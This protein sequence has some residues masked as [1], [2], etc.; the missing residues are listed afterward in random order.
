MNLPDEEKPP[1]PEPEPHPEPSPK[2]ATRKL[3]HQL[4]TAQRPDEGQGQP[5]S[6]LG[7][8]EVKQKTAETRSASVHSRRQVPEQTPAGPDPVSQPG[9]KVRN[10]A[11]GSAPPREQSDP[12]SKLRRIEDAGRQAPPAKLPWTY[13]LL[14]NKERTR[15]A[16][17]D[18]GSLLSVVGNAVL[19][20]LVMAFQ[21]RHL[22]TT[23]NGL[24]GGLYGNFGALGDATIST[25]ITLEAQVP[26]S[27]ML[28][29]QQLT[30]VTLTEAVVIPNTNLVMNSDSFAING[31]ARITLPRGTNLPIALTMD[32]PVQTT[33]P[34]SLLVPVTIPLSQTQLSSSFRNLQKVIQP[35][36]CTLNVD[37]Q[38]PE[39]I[40]LCAEHVTPTPLP[41]TP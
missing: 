33:I 15:A 23:L 34:I 37:A 41:G 13:R 38:Y 27:F 30:T 7:F 28:P 32:V 20:V 35:F 8:R 31:P 18:I 5:A 2:P 12:G 1:A 16:F 11:I 4:S 39:G 9:D 10:P 36:Y 24:M 17:W 14:L 22:R 29:V 26:V 25:N 21:I 19:L 3:V 40:Y 6:I